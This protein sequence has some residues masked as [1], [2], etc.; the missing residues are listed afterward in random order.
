MVY[1]TEGV[2]KL[3]R[4]WRLDGVHAQRVC[5]FCQVYVHAGQ[6]KQRENSYMSPRRQYQSR[7]EGG[8][9]GGEA[10]LLQEL[11]TLS[12]LFIRMRTFLLLMIYC[13]VY[14]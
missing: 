10:H 14:T 9:Q 13:T 3:I 2:N 5:T 4:I 8:R 11:K 7:G 1:H 12:L 6:Q